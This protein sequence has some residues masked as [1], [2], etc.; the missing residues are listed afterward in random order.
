MKICAAQIQPF[1]GDIEKNIALHQSFINEAIAA[2]ADLVFFP[3][4]SL[5]GYEPTLAKHLA[6]N[7]EDER[8]EVFQEMSDSSG[9]VIGLGLPAFAENGI[10]ISMLF[11]QPQKKRLVYSKQYLHEDELPYFASG[12]RQVYLHIKG[13]KLAPA[14]CYESLLPEHAEQAFKDGADIYLASVAKPKRGV[15]KAYAYF[16]LLAKKYAMPVIIVNCVG[17]C[18][19]FESVGG[20][21]AWGKD[22]Q[23]L[24]HPNFVLPHL[25]NENQLLVKE[26]INWFL[27]EKIKT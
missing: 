22:G 11:F 6:M 13:F 3:E 26:Y 18:D 15:D 14:I 24:S 23:V 9:I 2:E 7:S 19:D 5:T 4:L 12:D 16:P 1:K 27:L 21:A 10:R 17:F 20:S 25:I 8:L